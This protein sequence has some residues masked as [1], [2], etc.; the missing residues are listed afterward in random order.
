MINKDLSPR[1]VLIFEL[2]IIL[3]FSALPLLTELPYRV[4]IFLTW[5]GAYRMYIGQFPFKDFGMPL[6]YGFWIIPYLSF[7][8]FGPYLFSL[9]IAQAFMNLISLLT[10]RGILKIFGLSPVQSLISISVLCL[11]FILINFWP[12][13]NHTVFAFQLIGLYFLLG[14]LFKGK[15]F[16]FLGLASFFT[17]LCFFTKQDAGGLAFMLALALLIANG[18]IDK[19]FKSI[20]FFVGLY[21]LSL[22][23]LI[24]PLLRYDFSYWFNYGQP[25]HFSRINLSDFLSAFFEES[26]WIKFYITGIIII[27]IIRFK[28]WSS[29]GEDKSFLMFTLLTLG[30]M[31]QAMII[32]VTS[33]SPVTVNYYFHSFGIAFLLYSLKDYINFEKVWIALLLFLTILFWRSENYWKY[34]NRL[35]G[36]VL[37][38]VFSPPPPDAVSKHHWSSKRDTVK[39]EPVQWKLTSYKT[40]KRIKLPENTIEGIDRLLKMTKGK[41][42]PQ[43]LNMSNLSILAY[44]LGYTPESGTQFPLWYHK[45][46]AFFDRE[47]K[48]LCKNIQDKKYDIIIFEDLPDVNNFFPYAV[49]DCAL[50]KARYTLVDRFISPTG[51]A[52]D[53]VNV[54]VRTP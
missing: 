31:V 26:L 4:N 34:S 2:A 39:S 5:E 37:P 45:G 40:L 16:V 17:A 11:S 47:E 3:L 41:K 24:L 14:Y 19:E 49:R 46:V 18:F 9:V 42:N 15:R 52:T 32:Q 23:L 22:F 13:Y 8:L 6:G 38:S 20:L 29:I 44:E 21:I 25:P 51:Y 48:M 10:F 36:K 12:W 54:Y 1:Q 30:I 35:L 33:F 43:V 50:D 7:K 53:S 27:A 28:T